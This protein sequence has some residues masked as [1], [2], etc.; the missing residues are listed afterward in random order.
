MNK[1]NISSFETLFHDDE[2]L[3]IFNDTVPA[4]ILVLSLEDGK[5]VFSNQFFRDTLGGDGD[6]V[7]GASWEDFYRP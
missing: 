2:R 6:Q 3:K 5:V 1:L 7:L 4:G